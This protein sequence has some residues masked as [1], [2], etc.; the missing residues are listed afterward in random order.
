MTKMGTHFSLQSLPVLHD[1]VL[2]ERALDA[3]EPS[4]TAYESRGKCLLA[5]PVSPQ[6]GMLLERRGLFRSQVSGTVSGTS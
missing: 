3:F 5:M 6:V 2:Q 1:V 4:Q